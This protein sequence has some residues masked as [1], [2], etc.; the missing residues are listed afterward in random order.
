VVLASSGTIEKQGRLE[1]LGLSNASVHDVAGAHDTDHQNNLADEPTNT[2]P[3]TKSIP[4]NAA[5]INRRTG[6]LTI[7]KYYWNSIGLKKGLIYLALN[8]GY[9]FFYKFPRKQH[10]MSHYV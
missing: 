7:Y 3:Q 10:N 1:V 6:D 9:V 5:D 4:R 2:I 8:V